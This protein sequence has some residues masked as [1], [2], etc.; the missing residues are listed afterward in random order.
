MLQN[1]EIKEICQKH[2]LTRGEV[3]SIR[4][5]F[6][7]MCALSE[8]YLQQKEQQQ[9]ENGGLFD[10]LGNQDKKQKQAQ[11]EKKKNIFD[12]N[13]QIEGVNVEYFSK[14]SPFLSESLPHVAKRIL[15]AQGKY[16]RK[17]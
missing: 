10:S 14:Y 13:A 4:S 12:R 1:E 6:A 15:V 3:Y 11:Q 16:S 5:Q 9:G 2:A 17:R 8:Q 7:S